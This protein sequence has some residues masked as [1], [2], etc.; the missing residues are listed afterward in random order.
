MQDVRTKLFKGTIWLAAARVVTNLLGL[1]GTIV[2][3]RLLI[4]AD[5][6]LVAIG[7]TLLTI[8]NTVTSISMS[9]ALIQL[10]NASTA[11]FHTAWTLNLSRAAIVAAILAAAAFPIADFYEEPRLAGVILMLSLTI[12]LNG[13]ENPRAIMLTRDLVFWQQFM[14]QVSAKLVAL[15][16]SVLLAIVYQTYWALVLGAVCG[17][18]VGVLVSYTVLPFLPRPSF[19]HAKDLFSF[20][21]WLTLSQIVRTINF[22]MDQLLIGKLL[23]K[24]ELGYY[25]VGNNL[26]VIP[27]RE[28][29][30]PLTMTLFPAF[31]RVAHQRDRL[32]AAYQSAQSLV[33][34]IAFPVGVGV[35]LIA[36][37]LV[38]LTMGEKW[39]PSVLL[40]QVL[41]AVFGFQT[42]VTLSQPL[43]MAAGQ[44][45][46]V[47]RRDVQALCFRVPLILLG[48]YLG[49]LPG[50]VYARAVTGTTGLVFGAQ[51]VTRIT[52]LS[53]IEQMKPNIRALVSSGV[54]A[55][56][57]SGFSLMLPTSLDPLENGWKLAAYILVGATA[58][59][60]TTLG[61]WVLMQRPK[62]PE[63]EVGNILVKLLRMLKRDRTRLPNP[64][65]LGEIDK[66]G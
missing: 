21:L 13:L 40:I 30:A 39:L 55:V 12:L 36:D 9:E 2:L 25:T 23:G 49:G 61:L 20:S 24:A 35:A 14:L 50:L 31:S 45:R 10:R 3:A 53:F 59:I 34:A 33:T 58:Y 56:V 29:T 54:M 44:T 51:V 4:P 15:I 41:A 48:L 28:A 42:L 5:F 63:T 37:P 65:P 11:H 1:A 64:P 52:G 17:Q 27:S 60:S 8:I 62:G 57:V 19:H 16:V 18:A 32:A 22:N 47:F 6:G 66:D 43:A 7:T 26:A 46:F 38:R